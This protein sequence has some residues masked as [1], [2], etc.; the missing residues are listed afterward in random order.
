[1]GA[2]ETADTVTIYQADT[3]LDPTNAK[4]INFTVVFSWAV[5][6]FDASD[7]IL[8]GTAP[9]KF[10]ATVTGSGTTYMWPGQRK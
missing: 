10:T 9:G 2:Y 8:A 4:P 6:D 3:Q 5:S 7:V 1:M